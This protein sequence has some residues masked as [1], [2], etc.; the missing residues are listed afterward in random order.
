MFECNGLNGDLSIFFFLHVGAAGI[1]ASVL[2][3]VSCCLYILKPDVF[4]CNSTAS[5]WNKG[6]TY[7]GECIQMPSKL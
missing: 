7:A 1:A 2:E 3:L 5:I 6:T 4:S